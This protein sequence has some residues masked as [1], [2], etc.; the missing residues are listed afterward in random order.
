[1]YTDFVSCN[2]AKKVAVDFGVCL[3][4]YHVICKQEQFYFFLPDLYDFFSSSCLTALARISRI[5]LNRSSEGGHFYLLS[6]FRRIS[7]LSMMLTVDAFCKT[8]EMPF[9]L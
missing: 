2:F 7:P 1:L 8:G 4:I 5:M 6:N 3:W 9:Y